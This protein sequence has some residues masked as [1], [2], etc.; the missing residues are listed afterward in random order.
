ML[1][2]MQPFPEYLEPSATHGLF[3]IS[4]SAA[5][6]EHIEVVSVTGEFDFD[7]RLDVFPRLGKELVL[8]LGGEPARCPP[9]STRRFC[10]FAPE[11]LRSGCRDP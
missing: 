2:L 1:K 6:G 11:P 3:F 8:Q 4:A 10:A 7:L 5:A 9:G